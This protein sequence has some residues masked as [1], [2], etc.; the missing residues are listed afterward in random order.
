MEDKNEK[1]EEQD[2]IGDAAMNSA[3]TLESSYK[4]AVDNYTTAQD[5]YFKGQGDYLVKRLDQQ[6]AQAEQS[7]TQEQSAAYADYQKQVDPYG[8]QAEQAAASGLSNS[9]YAESLKTQAYVAY[10]N[11]MAVARQ[12]YLSAVASFDNTFTEAKMQNDLQRATIAFQSLQSQIEMILESSISDTSVFTE[13]SQW[14]GVAENATTRN[15]ALNILASYGINSQPKSRAEWR[16]ENEG[17]ES[18]QQYL[19]AFVSKALMN[20]YR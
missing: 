16:N 6:K 14:A 11:R 2:T 3:Q 7:Y 13:T 5:E 18:Y 15:K 8:V 19:K 1:I 9:G 10:Q 12:S 20:Q 4:E 17:Y